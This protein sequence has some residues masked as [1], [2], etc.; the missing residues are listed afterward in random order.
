MSRVRVPSIALLF[1]HRP[2][3]TRLK[4]NPALI[5]RLMYAKR[6]NNKKPPNWLERH[7][8]VQGILWL[9]FSLCQLACLVTFDAKGAF[10]HPLGLVGYI[11][12]GI[13]YF[14]F[15]L[16]SF[17][18]IFGMCWYAIRLMFMQDPPIGAMQMASLFLA[19]SL[20]SL[21]FSAI[22]SPP[23]EAILSQW[24]GFNEANLKLGGTPFYYFYQHA[25]Y[26][27]LGSIGTIIVGSVGLFLTLAYFLQLP[28][29]SWL[30]ELKERIFGSEAPKKRVVKTQEIEVDVTPKKEKLP[31]FRKTP[32]LALPQTESV[33]LY[34]D[35]EEEHPVYVEP[36]KEKAKK[37]KIKE[38][39]IPVRD[40]S[41]PSIDL[42]NTPKKNDQSQLVKELKSKADLLEETLL[43]FGIEAKVGQIH[44]GPTITS[45]EVHPAVGVKIGKIKNLEH[46]IALNLEAKAIRIIAP[47]PGKAAVG[48]EV[49]NL[50]PQEVSFK[51]ILLAYQQKGSPFRIPMLLGKGVNGDLV[52][53]DL[54]K[55]PH[56]IIAGATGSGKSVCINSIVMS[57]LMCKKP[58][59][60]RLLMI[61]PKKVELTQYTNL[62]HMLA[63]VI[64]EP[65]NACLALNWLVKEME[66]RYEILKLTGQRNIEAFNKRKINLEQEKQFHIEIPEKFA[67]Y[68]ALIDELADLMMVSSSDIETPIARIA[69]MARA[70]GIHMILATQRPSREVITGLIRANFPA[71]IAFKVASRINSQIILDDIGAENML[72]NGDMLF[73][74]PGQ[75]QLIRAQGVFV[76]DEEITT[77]I[78]SITSQAPPQYLIN[79]FDNIQLSSS[80]NEEE[81]ADTLFDEAKNIVLSTG[82]ASTT[83]LQ[84][85]LKIGYARAASLM[86]ML[87][88][89]GI[90]GPQEGARPRRVIFP[91]NAPVDVE[92]E[93]F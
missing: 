81:E 73:L 58:D 69:Q 1:L 74:M 18:I 7:P 13:W 9:V 88:A 23:F 8:E 35:I 19:G 66:K 67:Y 61:D 44:C 42:L 3:N 82:N 31:S 92:D 22:A 68:V 84:R 63:P 6:I 76:R 10:T 75:P 71:R 57:I 80:D 45:F 85:K 90:V 52:I 89:R 62:P 30:Q 17:V 41:L 38:I 72:G 87:E 12:A 56:C 36:K 53:A 16:A 51:E 4:N 55:M 83:F 43:S 47:I 21:I 77:V 32:Q 64:T 54:A 20:L 93:E 34:C 50:N 25:F 2:K 37:E 26:R 11:V 14:T 49:P 79:S 27:L 91:K 60:V 78:E 59:E 24:F 15:G 70:V 5:L 39:V 46:D 40:I 65:H 33:D 28:L 48:I 86:D 29:S